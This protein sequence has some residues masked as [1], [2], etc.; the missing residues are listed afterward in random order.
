M[1]RATAPQLAQT[2]DGWLPMSVAPKDGRPI[3]VAVMRG[4]GRGWFLHRV[5][6]PVR[7]YEGRWC[8]ARNNAPVF[9]WHKPVRWRAG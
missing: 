9:S 6:Y 3:A 2:P 1:R 7:F 5:P 4:S 8:Y